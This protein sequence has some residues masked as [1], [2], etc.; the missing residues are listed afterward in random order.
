MFRV[1]EKFDD[2]YVIIRGFENFEAHTSID[3]SYMGYKVVIFYFYIMPID[4]KAIAN[5]L[6]IG[7]DDFP[8]T[9]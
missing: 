3:L 6:V 1:F 5:K 2:A 8:I 9:F 4:S 7:F